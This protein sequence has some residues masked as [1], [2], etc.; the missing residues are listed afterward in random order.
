MDALILL[1]AF[2]LIAVLF[3]SAS[4]SYGADSRDG[5]R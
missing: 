4:T 3:G 1:F 5:F 2:V